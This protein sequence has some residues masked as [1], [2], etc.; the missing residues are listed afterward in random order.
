MCF[1][2]YDFL[3][4]LLFPAKRETTWHWLHSVDSSS[5]GSRLAC[6]QLERT[7]RACINS[8]P[9]EANSQEDTTGWN[10]PSWSGIIAN[11]VTVENK[12][13]TRYTH[14]KDHTQDMDLKR[15]RER[16][17]EEQ[18]PCYGKQTSG[19]GYSRTTTP[20]KN[21]IK[22]KV[23]IFIYM[24]EYNKRIIKEELVQLPHSTD[25]QLDTCC[26]VRA[27][28]SMSNETSVDVH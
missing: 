15:E 2:Y 12:R 26:A 14:E 11:R 3:F 13:K 23:Y 4:E 25:G 1:S 22:R 9:D 5:R 28:L 19:W 17:K 24:W 10:I 8:Q 21:R 18:G 27:L 20:D 6:S 7:R 16:K